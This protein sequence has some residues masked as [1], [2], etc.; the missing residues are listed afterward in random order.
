[1]DRPKLV[2]ALIAVILS[3]AAHASADHPFGIAMGQPVSSL[4]VLLKRER[5]LIVLRSAPVLLAPFTHVMVLAND[6]GHVCRV[7]AAADFDSANDADAAARVVA[8]DLT[9]SFKPAQMERSAIFYNPKTT[10]LVWRPMGSCSRDDLESEAEI[11]LCRS[12]FSDGGPSSIRKIALARIDTAK[13]GL[14]IQYDFI[15]R[16][17]CP[18]DPAGHGPADI[19]LKRHD[20]SI[21]R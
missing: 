14:L 17:G 4:D 20:T 16:D 6:R 2:G 9:A 1:M 8:A 12:T 5:G 13:P 3:T 19:I 15:N 21:S 10:A 7:M 18:S 11:R